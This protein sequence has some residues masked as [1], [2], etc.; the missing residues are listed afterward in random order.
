MR[1]RAGWL[2]WPIKGGAFGLVRKV[3]KGVGWL[4]LP[5][6]FAFFFPP[7]VYFFFVLD[8]ASRGFDLTEP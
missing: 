5:C 7:P 2:G 4:A 8:G 6:L 3:R 1:G